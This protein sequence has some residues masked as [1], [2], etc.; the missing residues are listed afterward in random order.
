MTSRLTTIELDKHYFEFCAGHFTMF[1]PTKREALHGHNFKAS[2]TFT[3]QVK[4]V[5]LCF[6][7]RDY[8]Q[9]MRQLCDELDHIFLI[10]SQSTFLTI[11]EEENYYQVVFNQETIPFLKHD[12]KLLPLRNISVEE[13][14]YW[15]ITQL[16][17]DTDELARNQIEEIV[18]KVYSGSSQSGSSRW[19]RLA[20]N[21]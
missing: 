18:V 2:L 11:V 13:L 6:D 21:C 20:K 14:S 4:E 9:K 3:A 10:P 1:S 17:H 19:E 12:V 15:F 5:G 16:T 7:Y 8:N